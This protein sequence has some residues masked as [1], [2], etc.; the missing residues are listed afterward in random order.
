LLAVISALLAL[1]LTLDDTMKEGCKLVPRVTQ[2]GVVVAS[3]E[4]YYI[5]WVVARRLL[6]GLHSEISSLDGK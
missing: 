6:S 3:E 2:G 5:Q 1:T 4:V